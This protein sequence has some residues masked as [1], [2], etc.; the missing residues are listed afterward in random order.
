MKVLKKILPF[1][2][3]IALWQL[4]SH[5]KLLNEYLLPS[6]INVFKAFLRLAKSGELFMDLI[7]SVRRVLIGFLMASLLGLLL[8]TVS[9]YFQK[10][11]DALTPLL[12]FLRPI[13]P[14]AWIPIAILWF[15][16]G[17]KPAYFI[18]FVGAFFP[19]FINSYWGIRDSRIMHLN[20]ARNFGASRFIILTDILLPG[21]LPRILHGL[22]IGLGLAW[23][24]VISAEL[25]GAQSGLGY[26]IQLNRIMLKTENI[27]AG[28]ITIGI[29]GLI[30]NFFMLILEKRLT[31]WNQ[32]TTIQTIE[33][34]E[35]Q[36]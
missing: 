10:V 34:K 32:Q 3:L 16:L 2:A 6:P 4:L 14:I 13:P 18:V 28:M 15:G 36:S 9:A 19:I 30:M 25:V 29:A 12:E 7:D 31:F 17:D 22:R 5:F 24:S 21:S 23:T 11:S 33:S 20:V 35:K 8:G 26:M 1:L 27:I